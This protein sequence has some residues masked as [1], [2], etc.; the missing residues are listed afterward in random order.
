M[1]FD[2]LSLWAYLFY[3]KNIF[4]GKYGPLGRCVGNYS[5][6]PQ[7]IFHVGGACV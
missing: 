4:F 1:A 2:Q 7:Y 5:L 6:S 3:A